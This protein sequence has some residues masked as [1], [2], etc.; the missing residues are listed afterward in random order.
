M[1]SILSGKLIKGC[2][3]GL[4]GKIVFFVVRRERKG[5]VEQIVLQVRLERYLKDLQHFY[6]L[7]FKK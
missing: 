4:I 1:A 6:F 5:K 2:G 7:F 3:G